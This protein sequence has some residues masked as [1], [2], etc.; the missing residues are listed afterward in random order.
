MSRTPTALWLSISIH[1]TRF[2]AHGPV[3]DDAAGAV[4][5]YLEHRKQRLEQVRTAVAQGASTARQVVEIVYAD[6]GQHLWPAAQL[7]VEAQLLYLR[8]HR[9]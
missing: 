3:I 8:K 6:V 5:F 1:S 2:T 9:S 4:A 7:S